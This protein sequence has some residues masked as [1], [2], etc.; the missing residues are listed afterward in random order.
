MKTRIAALETCADD[1]KERLV[2][3]E[4]RLDQTA[5]KSDLHEMASSVIKWIAGTA[6]GLGVA[7]I[8]VMTFALNNAAPKTLP[9]VP[10]PIVIYAQ[11]AAAVAAPTTPPPAVKR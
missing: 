8:T 10:A 1:A 9:S 4:T 11:P 6:A 2:K 5:T 3:I 7:G